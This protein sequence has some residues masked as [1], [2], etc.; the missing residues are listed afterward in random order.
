[1][2]AAT[3]LRAEQIQ[4]IA[5]PVP[6]AAESE[7]AY[8]PSDTEENPDHAPVLTVGQK[9]PVAV[10]KEPEVPTVVLGTTYGAVH[11]VPLE[12]L[13][14]SKAVSERKR[15]HVIPKAA[16]SITPQGQPVYPAF[17]TAGAGV[18]GPAV[19]TNIPD[20]AK[21]IAGDWYVTDYDLKSDEEIH[22]IYSNDEFVKHFK[23]SMSG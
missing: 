13:Q 19:E 15:E 16:S 2:R 7:V 4:T 11:R 23:I 12:G 20:D 14:F 1:M 17:T 3:K 22:K 10:A 8:L 9:A 18:L 6:A 5:Y 21:I